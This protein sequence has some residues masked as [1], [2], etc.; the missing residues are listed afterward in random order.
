VSFLDA[1]RYALDPDV[2]YIGREEPDT[3]QLLLGYGSHSNVAQVSIYL[4]CYGQTPAGEEL[5]LIVQLYDS[6]SEL[7]RWDTTMPLLGFSTLEFVH[8]FSARSFSDLRVGVRTTEIGMAVPRPGPG[9]SLISMCVVDVVQEGGGGGGTPPPLRVV[10]LYPAFGYQA[11]HYWLYVRTNLSEPLSIPSGFRF[12]GSP[13]GVR[14]SAG[15]LLL[16]DPNGKENDYLVL[17]QAI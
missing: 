16:P 1:L 10:R 12:V 13:S 5:N 11:A 4:R 8:S 3:A 2:D 14:E 7:Q 9:F 6:S 15:E 17:L